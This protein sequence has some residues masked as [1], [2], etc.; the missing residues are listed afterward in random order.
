VV[1]GEHL[2]RAAGILPVD[3]DRVSSALRLVADLDLQR[4]GHD[5]D[6]AVAIAFAV[7]R[8]AACRVPVRPAEEGGAVGIVSTTVVAASTRVVADNTY[9]ISSGATAG[10]I[11]AYVV[12]LVLY[13]VAF[14]RIL[15]QAGYSGW[16]VLIGLV[17][18]VNIVMFFVFA[19]RQWPVRRELEYYRAQ[20]QGG[21][22]GTGQYGQYR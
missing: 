20:Q 14:V 13:I 15:H 18:V 19:F 16:W 11:A 5:C 17:P 21:Q 9:H 22:Y 2:V 12:F 6:H 4:I 7:V 1:G 3:E 8:S 10:I